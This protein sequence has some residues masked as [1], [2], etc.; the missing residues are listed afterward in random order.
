[1]AKTAEL[2]PLFAALA[3]D[4]ARPKNLRT[5]VERALLTPL[6]DLKSFLEYAAQTGELKP[7]F[8]AL[9]DDLA[10]PENL[11]T[12]V[13]GALVTPLDHLQSFLT[14]AADNIKLR[15]A[16]KDLI[17]ELSVSARRGQLVRRFE[18]AS[19]DKL[20]S[21]LRSEV[22]SELW[23]SV[24]V[25]VDFD[26]WNRTR[27]NDSTTNL[28]AFVAFQRIAAQKGRP[29]LSQA[30]ALSLV[31]H[32]TRE[33]WHRPGI[34]LHHLSH[35]LR[36]ARC[37]WASDLQ[38][39]LDR[40]ATPD[41]VDG[42]LKSAPSGG[43]AGSLLGLVT[44]LEPGQRGW[45]VRD[46]LRERVAREISRR[47]ARDADSW[48]E[49]LSLLGA[50]V[51]IGIRIPRVDTD[52]PDTRE[53][54]GILDLRKPAPDRT[55]I[56]SLQVQL[57]L[58][59]REMARLNADPV[60]VLPSLADPILALWQATQQGETPD[61]LPPHVRALNAGTIAWLEYCKAAGWRLVPPHA[62]RAM[63]NPEGQT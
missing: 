60:T 16:F 13:E 4:L 25:A 63:D 28:D 58:G 46:A 36:W 5:L 12:L 30:P 8:A 45:F 33:D 10:R 2:K 38:S 53:L 62:D 41:W 59:L 6:S 24:F 17:N 61:T 27:G 26:A 40:I 11:R 15:P 43:L 20:V 51:G 56:G 7:V 9:A 31:L 1:L 23:D 44:T 21:V 3:D 29:E 42:L 34:G 55:T 52:W 47:G 54:S 18:N 49:A 37:A 32:S 35:V 57:W 39:F 22:T 19:L 48:A 50:A 14:F